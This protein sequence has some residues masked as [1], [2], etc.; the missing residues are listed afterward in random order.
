MNFS[1]PERIAKRQLLVIGSFD[2]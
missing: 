2:N 1:V